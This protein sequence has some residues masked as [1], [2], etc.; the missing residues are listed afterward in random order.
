MELEDTHQAMHLYSKVIGKYN[1]VV[2]IIEEE[3]ATCV[4]HANHYP[5]E[6][7]FKIFTDILCNALCADFSS[8][9]DICQL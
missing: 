6:E 1:H 4:M 7:C 8:V 2:I 5:S 9:T 3:A